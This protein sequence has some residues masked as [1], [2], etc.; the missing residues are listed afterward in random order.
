MV[1]LAAMVDGGGVPRPE[2][3]GRRRRLV[4]EARVR[5][6]CIVVL[7]PALDDDPRLGEAVEHLPV[8]QLVAELGVEALAVAVLPG[9]AG[10]DERGPGSH[11]GDPLSHGLGDEL[12]TVAHWEA[13]GLGG[14]GRLRSPHMA[15]QAAMAGRQVSYGDL[16]NATGEETDHDQ[17]AVYAREG[18]AGSDRCRQASQRGPDR[19]A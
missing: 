9:A 15:K 18:R 8:Q 4:A 3:G 17:C 19:G 1:G 16:A 2:H 14:H 7:A 10:L 11:R 13:R 6:L 5:A 12:G